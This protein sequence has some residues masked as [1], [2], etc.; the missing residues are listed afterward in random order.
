MEM[1]VEIRK[2]RVS[3]LIVLRN[4]EQEFKIKTLNFYMMKTCRS[5]FSKAFFDKCRSDVDTSVIS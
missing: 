1:G 4:L 2:R 5:S 3:L